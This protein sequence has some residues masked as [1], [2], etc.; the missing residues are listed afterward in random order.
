[1]MI[2]EA[3][4]AI[5]M[6]GSAPNCDV[7]WAHHLPG[8]DNALACTPG[9]F[10]RLSR[11]EVCETKTRPTLSTAERREVVTEYNVPSWS[12]ADGELDHRIP[13]FLGGRTESENIWPQPGG[14][15]NAKDK[16]EFRVYRR[17]CFSDPYRMRVRTGRRLFLADWRHAYRSWKEDGIL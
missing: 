17:I 3:L 2:V 5:S 1:M 14:I 6:F 12:G 8:P 16:V 4:V 11:R 10:E 15:P 7:N 9:S 13:V